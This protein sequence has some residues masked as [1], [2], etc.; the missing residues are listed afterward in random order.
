MS[1]V[2]YSE[3]IEWSV[4]GITKAHQQ[5]FV[6]QWI[7][8]FAEG[9]LDTWQ[10]RVH[11]VRSLLAEI[12][13]VS[14][15]ALTD[16]APARL[17]LPDLIDEAVGSLAR[18]V[19]IREEC[20]YVR[21]DLIEMRQLFGPP[22]APIGE[23]ERRETKVAPAAREQV[24][25]RPFEADNEKVETIA[26]RARVLRERVS[27]AYS[28]SVVRRLRELLA[29]DGQ[30]KEEQIDLTMTLATEFS[31]RGFSLQHL[32]AAA[33]VLT[34]GPSDFLERFDSL[35]ALCDQK[36][37]EFTAWFVVQEWETG[38]APTR[39]GMQLLAPDA[40]K[41]LLPK[42]APKV[43]SFF[44]R[45]A[46]TDR[47][48]C[49]TTK[50]MD[51]YAARS[52]AESL[53]AND[54]A[55]LAFTTFRDPK[56]KLNQEA[57]VVERAT[58]FVTQATAERSRSEFLSRSRD[59]KERAAVLLRMNEV[60]ED[61]DAHHLSATLQYYRL[62]VTHP[63]EQVRLVN[64]WVAAENLVRRAGGGSIVQ[65]VASYLVPMLA[66]RNVRRVTGS[67]ARRLRS[68]LRDKA[69]RELGLLGRGAKEIPLAR[70]LIAMRDDEKGSAILSLL[71][72][73]PLLRYRLTRFVKKSLKDG[74]A[75]AAYLENNAR[76]IEWQLAR[77]YRARNAVVHRGEYPRA[78]GQLLQHLQ[79]YVWTAIRQVTSELE[80]SNGA[81]SLSD[82]L[83]HWRSLFAHALRVCRSCKEPPVAALCD[84]TQFLGLAVTADE[85]PSG[86][87]KYPP[88][89]AS[90]TKPPSPGDKTATGSTSA[91]DAKVATVPPNKE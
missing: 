53:L 78:M 35:V 63:S 13:E 74:P 12:E 48:V 20:P 47:L 42:D 44:D 70:L 83:E 3:P 7:E 18:D 28:K 41:A 11:N 89:T 14:S 86:K 43:A 46:P 10:V 75:A 23:R 50:A 87:D 32:R 27:R 81:W 52:Q 6:L 88:P 37:R 19:V 40:A 25:D 82:A 45:V 1:K 84:P 60:L 16:F 62:A 4:A 15:V 69:L 9:S 49:L 68:V 64:L 24:P 56:L 58:S 30:K 17:A 65:R 34:E 5:L 57:V 67:L 38:I 85:A 36:E 26:R 31:A 73:D 90:V 8:L 76:N 22:R 72:H 51:S 80:E 21:Q 33:S 61:D 91:A 29:G 39:T 54:F 71:N 2:L 77:I 59:Y 66:L 79:T 55:A